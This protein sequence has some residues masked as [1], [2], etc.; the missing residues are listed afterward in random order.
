M[1]KSADLRRG[2]GPLVKVPFTG[3]QTAAAVGTGSS[4]SVGTI[5]PSN[6]DGRNQQ[7]VLT[8]GASTGVAWTGSWAGITDVVYGPVVGLRIP[9]TTGGVRP[10]F[11]VEIDG[12]VYPIDQDANLR[13]LNQPQMSGSIVDNESLIVVAS[14]LADRM[15]T[16]TVHVAADN[17]VSGGAARTLTVFGWVAAQGRG[18]HQPQVVRTG[19]AA[20]SAPTALTTSATQVP[21]IGLVVG[22]SLTNTDTV[23]RVVTITG[24][25]GTTT[26]R[27]VYLA[28]A[29]TAGDTAYVPTPNRRT[30]T[31]YKW[32]A[33]AATVV[34][35]W[36]EVE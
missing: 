2:I 21:A 15:H 27:R 35:G 18:Y 1:A 30:M 14:G 20:A 36:V 4:A 3:A 5:Q 11:D 24:P 19:G 6:A 29:G 17:A 32:S 8:A 33:D 13:Y 25:D 26:W 16:V 9:R 34:K 10:P 23:A 12:Q 31:G 22:L 28:I 7:A